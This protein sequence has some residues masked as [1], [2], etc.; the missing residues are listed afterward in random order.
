[1]SETE[2]IQMTE[3]P[4]TADGESS[5][6]SSTYLRYVANK[7]VGVAISLILVVLMSFFAFRIQIGRAHV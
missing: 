2:L 6:R 1:M 4:G 7:F 3:T 5:T